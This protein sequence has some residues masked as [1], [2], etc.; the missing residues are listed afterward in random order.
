M[1]KYFS[2]KSII[3]IRGGAARLMHDWI[4]HV[5]GHHKEPKE[6]WYCYKCGAQN[7]RE[8][9]VCR[10]CGEK[11]IVRLTVEPIGA[12]QSIG[13]GTA[14]PQTYQ[15]TVD[16]RRIPEPGLSLKTGVKV[17]FHG[18]LFALIFTGLV[19][20]WVFVT[21]ILVSIGS[22]IG[23]GIGLGLLVVG[24]G[25]I[26]AALGAI[27]WN[28]PANTKFW[29]LFLHGLAVG[30]IFLFVNIMTYLVPNQIYP[31]TATYIVT[32]IA[33]S[34]IDGAVGRKAALWFGNQ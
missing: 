4:H 12:Q 18:F 25:G 14:E 1:E 33:T 28:I 19:V 5:I 34:L 24:I 7:P 16:T 10:N 30:A 31:G 20:A 22:L 3:H 2:Y 29:T 27:L 17:L 9:D 23:L 6:S 32:M 26:N 21:L 15:S 13:D 11:L 8:V